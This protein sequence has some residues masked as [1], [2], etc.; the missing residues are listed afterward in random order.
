[1]SLIAKYR[2]EIDE[3]TAKAR[4]TKERVSVDALDGAEIYAYPK[5]GDEIAWGVNAPNNIIRGVRRKDGADY[6]VH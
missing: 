5:P 1:M 3:A 4:R 2:K 6:G